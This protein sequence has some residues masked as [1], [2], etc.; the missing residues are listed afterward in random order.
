LVLQVQG[1]TTTLLDLV[2]EYIKKGT[3]LNKIGY[4]AFT[5]KSS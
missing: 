1:K 2:D 5:R 4:F 3:S